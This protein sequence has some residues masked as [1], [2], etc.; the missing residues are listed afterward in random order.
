MKKIPSAT[1]RPAFTVR[2]LDGHHMVVFGPGEWLVVQDGDSTRNVILDADT[3]AT[4]LLEAASGGVQE[5]FK[6]GW[7]TMWELSGGYWE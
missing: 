5:E 1:L 2:P 6:R 3:I 7:G 4:L